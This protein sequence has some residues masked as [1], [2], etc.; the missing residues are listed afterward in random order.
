LLLSPPPPKNNNKKMTPGVHTL[1]LIFAVCLLC[2]AYM[3]KILL[4]IL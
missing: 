2:L 4:P 3:N 1:Q